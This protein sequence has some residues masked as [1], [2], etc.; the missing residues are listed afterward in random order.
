MESGESGE[1]EEGRVGVESGE[2]EREWRVESGETL[3]LRQRQ[4]HRGGSSV[5]SLTLRPVTLKSQ[6]PL[7]SI[8]HS[9]T[10]INCNSH[11]S[12]NLTNSSLRPMPMVFQRKW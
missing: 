8:V 12:F 10:A 5:S 4:T 9:R 11:T 2:G 6:W 1:S 3:P 7:L